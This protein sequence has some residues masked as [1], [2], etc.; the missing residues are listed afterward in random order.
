[1]QGIV[2]MFAEIDAERDVVDI[3]EQVGL[4]EMLRQPVEDA[5][6]HG[7][8]GSAVGE[9]DLWRLVRSHR[10]P[11]SFRD[12]GRLDHLDDGIEFARLAI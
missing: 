3:D 10:F 9:D 11:Q 5:P 7:G 2:D 6:G 4:A 8:I 1:L 12:G